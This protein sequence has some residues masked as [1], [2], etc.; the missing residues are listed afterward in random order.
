MLD[1]LKQRL[2]PLCADGIAL[3]FSGG[4]DSSLLL[5]VLAEMR[6]ERPFPLVALTMRTVLQPPAESAEAAAFAGRF[7]VEH[8]VFTFNPLSI[9]EVRR[10]RIDRCYHCKKAVF[11]LFW[12]YAAEHGFKHVIDGTN[13]DDAR[14]YRPGRKA[15]R[16]SGVLSPLAGF[17][18]SD[19]R[20]LSA[21]LDLPTASKPAAPC[22]ATR[23]EYDTLLTED[24]IERVEKGEAFLKNLFPDVSNVRLRVHKNLARI[25]VSAPAIPAIAARAAEIAAEMKRLGFDF[26]TLDLDGFRSGCFDF[27]LKGN[28]L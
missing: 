17:S 15:L 27:N 4:V 21:Q 12:K 28:E 20:A 26:T 24:A 11:A 9:D 14:A 8:R 13:G 2:E 6:R 23:F 19:I 5:A 1:E 7:G 3:A 22:L 18:K 10:N 25:E 16:E